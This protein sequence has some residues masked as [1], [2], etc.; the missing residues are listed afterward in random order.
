[1]VFVELLFQLPEEFRAYG[2]SQALGY[3]QTSPGQGRIH[4]D[5]LRGLGGSLAEVNRFL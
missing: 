5:G 3:L 4:S 2:K 1:V